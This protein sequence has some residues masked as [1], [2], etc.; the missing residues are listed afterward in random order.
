MVFLLLALLDASGLSLFRRLKCARL[1]YLLYL[2]V[3]RAAV[4]FFPNVLQLPDCTLPL[5][6]AGAVASYGDVLG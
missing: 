1:M 3:L 2:L 5:G 6:L 4:D